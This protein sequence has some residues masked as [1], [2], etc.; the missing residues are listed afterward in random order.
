[1]EADLE[2]RTRIFRNEVENAKSN[3]IHRR[4]L[5]IMSQSFHKV[6]VV[7]LIASEMALDHV[8]FVYA[9]THPCRLLLLRYT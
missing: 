9:V 6:L 3:F 5:M 8:I 2:S 7:P 1:M 4:V